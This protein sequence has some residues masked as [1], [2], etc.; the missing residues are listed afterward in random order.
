MLR[1]DFRDEME[2]EKKLF[3]EIG[4]VSGEIKEG[5]VKTLTELPESFP[6]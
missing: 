2:N 1:I 3:L 4:I 5:L 6:E